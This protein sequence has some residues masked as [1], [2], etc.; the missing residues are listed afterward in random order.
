MKKLQTEFLAK[1]H[2]VT[3]E[4]ADEMLGCVP[5]KRQAVNGFLVG[6]ATDHA[7]D[8]SGNYAARF[9][10]IFSEGG[11]FYNGGLASVH[12]FE[13]FLLPEVYTREQY[14]RGEVTHEKYFGQFVTP[15]VK[16]IVLRSI[17]LDELLK[18]TDEHMNDIPLYRWDS[19]VHS[20]LNASIKQIKAA[21]EWTTKSTGVC[22]AKAAAREI[23][24]EARES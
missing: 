9:Q 18:S 24:S 19:L 20:I 14:I 4:Y 8:A 10:L 3:Q 12:D 6:E 13:T 15:E 2:E 7:K 21:D 23:I 22:I 11:K 16:R 17:T 1:T 5:P